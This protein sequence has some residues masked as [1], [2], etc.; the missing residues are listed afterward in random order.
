MRIRIALIDDH[1][2]YLDGLRYVI[3]AQPDMEVVGDAADGAAALKLAREKSPDILLLDI[4]LPGANGIEVCRQ[5]RAELPRARIIILT[6]YADDAYVHQAVEAGVNGYL[7]KGSGTAEISRAI[8]AVMGGHT[9]LS[10][11]VTNSVMKVYKKYLSLK[12]APRK[13][14]LSAREREVLKWIAEGLST[15]EI[16]TRL[17]IGPKTVETYRRRLMVKLDCSRATELVRYALREGIAT[18]D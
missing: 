9:Y 14:P 4:S 11:E 6:A 12:D 1:P 17:E 15:K 7:L 18:L 3:G 5:I 2:I 13:P 16:A 10:P 8:R